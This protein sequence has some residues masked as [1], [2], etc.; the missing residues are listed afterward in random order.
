MTAQE[1]SLDRLFSRPYLWGTWP[2][3]IAWARKAHRL[4]FLWNAQSGAVRDL[5]VYNADSKKL[6]RVTDLAG[7][8]DAINDSEAE[9]DVH[10]KLYLQ[11]LTGMTAFD[12]SNDG[13]KAVFSYRGD[14][15]LASVESGELQRLTKTK[16]PELDP[17]FNSDASR[18]ACVASGQL[19]VMTIGGLIEQKTDIKMPAVL[20]GFRW[21]PDGKYL[22]FSVQV[23]P[24][25]SVTLPIYSGQF[26]TAAPFPRSV[27]G[28]QPSESQL[29]VIESSGDSAERVLETGIMHTARP[30]EWAPDSKKLLVVGQS[31]DYKNQELRVVDIATA[32][33]SVV[34]RQKDD[35]WVEVANAGWSP[36][37][38]RLW[39]TSDQSGFQHLYVI[40]QDGSGKRQIT[41]GNWEVHNDIFSHSPQWIGNFIYY[42]STQKSTAVRQLYRAAVDGDAAEEK[43]SNREGVNV[44]WV[45]EMAAS[46]LLEADSK[47]PLDLYVDG[48]RVTKSPLPEFYQLKWAETK[49]VSYPSLKDRK[50]VAGRLLLPPGYKP[51]DAGQTPRPAVVYIHGSGYAT[52]V[53]K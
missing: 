29:F 23:K 14:L 7:L 19:F 32:R 21:S 36:D 49:Y 20:S 33:S 22:S 47:N 6:A 45:T 40:N 52:S 4:G 38:S 46:A 43:L 30:P 44:G 27:A 8:K 34:F 1:L 12:L 10:R 17:R 26:V 31:S 25:R 13:T 9:Q 16:A 15:F 11:P 50:P 51:D 48:E 24:E 3:Q 53:L 37:S 39:F 2:S 42:S 28:D 35:R 5:Y 41:K 18:I